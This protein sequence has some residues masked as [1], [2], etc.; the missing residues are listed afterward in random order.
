MAIA[1]GVAG[2]MFQAAADPLARLDRVSLTAAPADA[3]LESSGL[4]LDTG[5]S[6]FWSQVRSSTLKLTGKVHLNV[7]ELS[8][9]PAHGFLQMPE[10]LAVAPVEVSPLNLAIS[11][12]RLATASVDWDVTDWGSLALT[13]SGSQNAFGLSGIADVAPLSIASFSA[14]SASAGVAARVRLGDGWVTSFSYNTG[15]SQLSLKDASALAGDSVAQSRSYGIAIA[16][17]G[18]F[19]DQDALGLS[20][21]R[22]TD[23]YFG[24]VNLAGLDDHINLLSDYRRVSLPGDRQETDLALGYVT[25]FLNGKLALQA[26][27]G[28]Q[29]NVAGQSGMN[30]LTVLSRAKINF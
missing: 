29:M 30:S 12:T 28:Y 13:A 25:T 3:S 19:G 20:V 26:N 15:I 2:I 6:S 4:G 22:R 7:A 5:N 23:D 27:A 11:P 21:S 16:K 14:N 9:D 1:F 10:A 8:L 18:L 24:N 17:H